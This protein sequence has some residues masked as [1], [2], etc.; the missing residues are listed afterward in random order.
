LSPKEQYIAQRARG[1]YIASVCQPEVSFDLSFAAQVTNLTK[2][3]AKTL[4]KRLAWQ[5][6]NSERGLKFVKLDAKTLQLLVFMD[7]L[8]ANNKDLLSQIRYDIALSD[9]T[10]KANII[11]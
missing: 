6:K 5:I 4:N 10:K 1:A 9:A 11:Y 7:V 8:F 2:D 3:N